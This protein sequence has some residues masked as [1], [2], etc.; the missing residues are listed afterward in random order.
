[1]I[2]IGVY[3]GILLELI[4]VSWKDVKTKKISNWWA[5]SNILIFVILTFVLPEYYI[6]A[7]QTF[8][9]SAVFLVIGFILFLLN[10][11]GAGDTKYLF[12]FF[13]L[14][15]M[16]LQEQSFFFLLVSTVVTGL[17]FFF[18]N[19]ITNFKKIIGYFK[20]GDFE[21]VKNCFGSKFAFAP[22]ILLAWLCI[23]W[24]LKNSF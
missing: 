23:G 17:I 6:W 13:L 20:V 11:M 2:P 19:A 3:I 18:M 12:S 5:I 4:F 21:G 7:W 24:Y 16:G 9:Y 10:I 8:L 22:V 14:V 15:P 1:M